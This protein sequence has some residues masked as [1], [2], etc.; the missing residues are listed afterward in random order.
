MVS[1]ITKEKQTYPMLSNN[2]TCTILGTDFVRKNI[3]L[4]RILTVLDT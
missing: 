2:G 1:T 3:M 4:K